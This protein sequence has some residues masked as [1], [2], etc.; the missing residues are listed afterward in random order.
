M[1][2]NKLVRRSIN[3]SKK[4]FKMNFNVGDKVVSL[5][6]GKADE[7]DSDVIGT[8]I[9]ATETH[10]IVQPDNFPFIEFEYSQTGEHNEPQ[11]SIK[12]LDKGLS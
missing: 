7:N 2:W 11:Y 3:E 12:K 8:V 1:A 6:D 10:C 5:I 4:G 9:E